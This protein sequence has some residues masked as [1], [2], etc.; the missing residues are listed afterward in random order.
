M[1]KR[2]V[3]KSLNA[4]DGYLRRVGGTRPPSTNWLVL[5]RLLPQRQCGTLA[6]RLGSSINTGHHMQRR[7]LLGIMLAACAAPAF[8]KASSLMPIYVPSKKIIVPADVLVPAGPGVLRIYNGDGVVLASLGLAPRGAASLG[9]INFESQG[10]IAQSGVA[11][12]ARFSIPGFKD[13]DVSIGLPDSEAGIKLTSLNFMTGGYA[14]L[15]GS[16]EC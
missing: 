16:L 11:S 7:S 10:E 13:Q 5:G 9:K 2:P 3:M 4:A 6:G 15:A 12:F 14:Q 8:V 1:V